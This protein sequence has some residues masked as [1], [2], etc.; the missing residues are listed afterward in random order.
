MY[1][2]GLCVGSNSAP[3][4]SMGNEGGRGELSALPLALPCQPPSS[5]GED[6][7]L[8]P[9]GWVRYGPRTD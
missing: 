9:L 5:D 8:G 3:S 4:G 7:L 6:M 2:A 1:I